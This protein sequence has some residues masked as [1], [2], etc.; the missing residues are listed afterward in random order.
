VYYPD[1]NVEQVILIVKLSDLYLR[2]MVFLPTV[3]RGFLQSLHANAGVVLWIGHCHK[4]VKF[5]TCKEEKE[6]GRKRERRKVGEK[7]EW[8]KKKGKEK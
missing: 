4:I 8:E 6:A 1:T 2:V 3:C 7:E 5:R